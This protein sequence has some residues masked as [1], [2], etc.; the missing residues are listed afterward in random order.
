MNFS[1]NVYIAE[2]EELYLKLI[3]LP[4]VK[5][6]YRSEMI[7][8]ELKMFFKQEEGIVYSYFTCDES[9]NENKFAVYYSANNEIF[10][11]IKKNKKIIFF[12]FAMVKHY[13]NEIN[14]DNFFMIIKYNEIY[15]TLLYKN[16]LLIS[17]QLIKKENV[18]EEKYIFKMIYSFLKIN[19]NLSSN[20]YLANCDNS[21]KQY[22]E[23]ENS[24]ENTKNISI[25][26]LGLL[27]N[28]DLKSKK[29]I[30]FK[31]L[32]EIKEK[33]LL[34]N[35]VGKVSFYLL[36]FFAV[37]NLIFGTIN[38]TKV[39]KLKKANERINLISKN[40][41]KTYNNKPLNNS[42][43]ADTLSNYEKIQKFFDENTEIKV[44]YCSIDKSMCIMQLD[45]ITYEQ[46][47]DV[48]SML[49]K[50]KFEINDISVD[51]NEVNSIACISQN[52]NIVKISVSFRENKK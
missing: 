22:I 7:R 39:Y 15:Y 26:D 45:K 42:K 12:Q 10:N 35:F 3:S 25:T 24:K 21:I 27:K 18:S 13:Y 33:S 51:N 8:N 6:K 9:K 11:N 43:K 19:Y 20:I 40:S 52:L 47:G 28:I 23:N 1:D 50:N 41:L 46:Y 4:Q 2:G 44:N 5:R 36:I 14:V 16:K 31:S 34:K 38:I 32:Y 37:F 49:K 48:L 30:Y 17:N 29:N